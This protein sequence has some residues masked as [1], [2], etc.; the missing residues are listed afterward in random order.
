MLTELK[1][2][3]SEKQEKIEQKCKQELVTYTCTRVDQKV[4]SGFPV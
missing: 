4:S 2:V 3:A 1:A